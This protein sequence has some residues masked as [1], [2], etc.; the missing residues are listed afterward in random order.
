MKINLP[1]NVKKIISVLEENG[2][3]A[4]AVGGCV[5]DSLIGKK[6]DDWDI[7]CSAK[8]EQ[9]KALFHKTIDT[10][11]RHGTVTVMMKHVG[12]EVTTYR[13]DGEYVDGRHPKK[14]I[15]TPSLTKDLKR[16]DFTI[17]AMAYSDRTGIVDIFDGVGDLKKKVIRC[18]GNPNERFGEDALRILRAVRFSAQLGFS[19]EEKT[20]QAAKELA[21]NLKKISR[22]RIHTELDKLIMSKHPDHVKLL[23]SMDILPHIFSGYVCHGETAALADRLMRSDKEHYIRWALFITNISFENLLESLKFDNKSIKICN[24]M[25]KYADEELRADKAYVRRMIVKTGKDIFRQYYLPFRRVLGNTSEELL[26]Q[27]EK[28]YDDIIESG[29]CLSLRE[30]KINGNDLKEAGIAE[31]E[32]VGEILNAL[33]YQV[34]EDTSINDRDR[35]LEL[36]KIL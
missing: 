32:R 12:Y 16:R 7:A 6:P 19:I 29:D 35:L 23:E 22:E 21:E 24:I 9:V 14:V 13:I 34:L 8:P 36:A 3:E 33:L 25:K 18:V 10:G 20:M 11:I 27:V 5:R 2:F 30:M 26:R 17:N 4:Y 1:Y 31:G 28:A 15:F